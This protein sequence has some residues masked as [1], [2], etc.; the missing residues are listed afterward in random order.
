VPLWQSERDFAGDQS[1]AAAARRFCTTRLSRLF[2]R[3]ADTDDRIGTA[4]LVVSELVTNAVRAGSTRISVRLTV[5]DA[6]LNV[7]VRDDAAGR[8]R[9]R[10]AAPDERDGRG[11]MIVEALSD[12]WGVTPVPPISAVPPRKSVWARFSLPV[13][14]T[15]AAFAGRPH[16]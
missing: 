8:P 1:A 3:D 2:G 14:L 12:S 7:S 13:A 15:E 6:Y 5:D 9:P 11:L 10:L 16:P 4:E